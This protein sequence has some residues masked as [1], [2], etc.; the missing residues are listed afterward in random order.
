VARVKPAAS[1]VHQDDMEALFDKMRRSQVWVLGTPV[2]WWWAEAPS[3]SCS[4][5]RCMP[6]FL[7]QDKAIFRERRI[8]LVIPWATGRQH[9]PPH[10]GMFP[11][12]LA[13]VE[14]DLVATV[15]AP[16]VG[17]IVASA[18]PCRL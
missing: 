15:L 3:L 9:C 14:A 10:V 8:V 6:G 16:G 13:Y 11:D 12:A 1:C 2:Y 7:D 4:S 5:I 17:C 18:R